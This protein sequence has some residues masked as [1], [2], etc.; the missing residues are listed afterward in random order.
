MEDLSYR[1]RE[2]IETPQDIEERKKEARRKQI[3]FDQKTGMKRGIG[4]P[5]PKSDSVVHIIK[6][7]AERAEEKKRLQQEQSAHDFADGSRL[8][9]RRIGWA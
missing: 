5:G 9:L 1:S 6:S 4:L 8:N 3:E 7:A 2:I